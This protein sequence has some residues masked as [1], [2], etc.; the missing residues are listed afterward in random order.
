M[1]PYRK[2][3]FAILGTVLL[4]VALSSTA[5]TLGRARG[6]VILGQPLKLAVPVQAEPQDGTSAPCFD[7]DVFYGDTKLEASRVAVSSEFSQTSLAGSVTVSADARVDEPVVT[8]YLRAGCEHKSTRRYVVLADFSS[9][10]AQPTKDVR[11]ALRIA[12]PSAA[13]VPKALPDASM[14]GPITTDNS[15]RTTRKPPTARRERTPSEAGVPPAEAKT[16]TQRRAHLKLVPLDLTVEHVPSLKLSETVQIAERE[17]LQRRAEAIALWRAL[18]ASPEDILSADRRRQS[19]EADLKGLQAVTAKNRETLLALTNRLERAE[20]ER[21]FNPVVY[22]LLAVLLACSAGVGYAW[23]RMRQGGQTAAPWWRN[24]GAIGATPEWTEDGHTEPPARS[25]EAWSTEPSDTGIDNAAPEF[26]EVDIDL[27]L[28]ESNPSVSESKPFRE[29][30]ES[31]RPISDVAASRALGHADFAHSMTASLRSLNTKEM[32]DVRQQAEFFMTLGQHE[33]AIALLKDS[34]GR[35]TDSNPLVY[36]DLLRLLHTLGRKTEYDQYRVDFNALFSGRVPVYSE[37]NQV[38]Q[39]LEAYPDVCQRISDLWPTQAAVEYMEECM[40]G[41][42]DED[43]AGGFELEAFR[44]LLL[45]HG[46]AQR[47][48]SDSDTGMQPFSATRAGVAEV[49]HHPSLAESGLSDEGTQP[50]TYSVPPASTPPVDLDLSEPVPGNLIDFNAADLGE[51]KT[52]IRKS[53]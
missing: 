22:G 27:H 16:P 20:S 41:S 13:A 12:T 7:A 39:G 43:R 18:N 4:C 15:P 32:L 47:M 17:D 52:P 36:L 21:Y 14:A 2:Y 30:P 23:L 50:G 44:D 6:A 45:L 28:G 29:A 11:D 19:M 33:E 24:D 31:G 48:A 46:I 9:E 51:F 53:D 3:K 5:L 49:K 34:I 25:A 8:V 35:S 37:F 10:A 38:R 40:A 42:H 1:I 26:T